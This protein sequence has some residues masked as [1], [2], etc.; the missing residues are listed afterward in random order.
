[1]PRLSKTH[2]LVR[3][4]QSISLSLSKRPEGVSQ[5]E[6][7]AAGGGTRLAAQIG[8]LEAKGHHFDHKREAEG[9]TRYRWKGWERPSAPASPLPNLP[10]TYSANV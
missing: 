5:V 7:T 9:Y 8:K 10:G 3:G 6:A 4:K 2:P 1:M